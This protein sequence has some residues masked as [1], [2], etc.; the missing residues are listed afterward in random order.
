MG[1]NRYDMFTLDQS[2]CCDLCNNKEARMCVDYIWL[3]DKEIGNIK[4]FN[5][6]R[7]NCWANNNLLKSPIWRIWSGL[8][9]WAFEPCELVWAASR[10][11][12]FSLRKDPELQLRIFLEKMSA[13]G[14]VYFDDG[15]AQDA[16][17]R[18]MY[19]TVGITATHVRF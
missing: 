4:N 18:G 1:Y 14:S 5:Q 15:M 2:H 11:W 7:V 6:V 10:S 8:A 13:Q 17:D 12:T 9:L 3:F 16:V 19:L